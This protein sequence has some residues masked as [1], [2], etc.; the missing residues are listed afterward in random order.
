MVASQSA[1]QRRR[2]AH[3][4]CHLSQGY[5]PLWW[6]ASS[7]QALQWCSL[8]RQRRGR[9]G[10]GGRRFLMDL[11]I[12]RTVCVVKSPG[13]RDGSVPRTSRYAVAR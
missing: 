12:G 13:D 9:V 7:S 10:A 5:S 8:S 6:R 2:V 1:H 3:T 11:K 4:C